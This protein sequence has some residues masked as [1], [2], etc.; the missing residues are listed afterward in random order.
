MQFDMNVT[1]I[2]LDGSN[3]VIGLEDTTQQVE[4]VYPL[5]A[6]V[7]PD[8]VV[9]GQDTYMASVTEYAMTGDPVD[10]EWMG[11]LPQPGDI[12]VLREG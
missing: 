6:L 8:P 5:D 12:Q 11:Y 2:H 3:Q 1:L 4:V 9:Y 7:G 10:D